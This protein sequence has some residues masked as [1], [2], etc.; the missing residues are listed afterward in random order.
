MLAEHAAGNAEAE[1]ID[2]G[3]SVSSE[4]GAEGE[5][6]PILRIGEAGPA[7]ARILRAHERHAASL[8]WAEAQVTAPRERFQE[9]SPAGAKRFAGVPETAL[10]DDRRHQLVPRERSP[11]ECDADR[12]PKGVQLL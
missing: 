6:R 5:L 8:V 11:L 3:R 9:S 1:G 7:R 2:R 12:I 10:R 4:V